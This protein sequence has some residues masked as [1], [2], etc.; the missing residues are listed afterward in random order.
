MFVGM[1]G[2]AFQSDGSGDGDVR[3]GELETGD[4]RLL[5]GNWG[6]GISNCGVVVGNWEMV[7]CVT[8]GAGEVE[9]GGAGATVESSR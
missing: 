1:T 5:V 9:V 3:I 7:I 8:V 4:W 6:L 2:I